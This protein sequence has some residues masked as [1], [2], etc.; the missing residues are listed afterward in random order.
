MDFFIFNVLLFFLVLDPRLKLNYY[1]DNEWEEPYI[2]EIQNS[3][4]DL[5]QKQYAPLPSTVV[6]SDQNKVRDDNL[7]NHIYKKQRP[8]NENELNLYLNSP[9]VSPEINLLEWWKV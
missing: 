8:S 9:T 7:L 6:E 5:Y 2:T 1:K 4:S 3:I